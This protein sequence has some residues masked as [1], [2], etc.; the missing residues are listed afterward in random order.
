MTTLTRSE[1]FTQYNK[2]RAAAKHGKLNA[3]RVNKALSV[4]QSKAQSQ[5]HTTTN[6]CD[7]KARVYNPRVVCGH[8]IAKMVEYR[9]AGAKPVQPEPQPIEDERIMAPGVIYENHAG[10]IIVAELLP[11]HHYQTH[12]FFTTDEAQAWIDAGQH[13]TVLNPMNVRGGYRWV[14]KVKH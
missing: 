14:G 9:A 8:M 13:G 3:Q 11:L 4:L 6:S 5:Y 1:I 7:C 2:A 12:Y 10:N